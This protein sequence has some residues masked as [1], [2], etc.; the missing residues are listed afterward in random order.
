MNRMEIKNIIQRQRSY[1][2]S[3]ATL[4][5]KFRRAS[6]RA[7]YER[8]KSGEREISEALYADLGKS[9]YESYMCEIGQVLSEL[10]YMIKNV[11]RFKDVP[12]QKWV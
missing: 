3:G 5:V 12:P 9:A 7:L 1:F 6:L 4:D 11:G 10:R 8:I 2:E